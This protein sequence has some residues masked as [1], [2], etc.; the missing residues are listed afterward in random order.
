MYVLVADD[1][2][3]IC[4]TL[5]FFLLASELEAQIIGEVDTAPL[6]LIRVAQVQP[7][8]VLLDWELPGLPKSGGNQ[9]FIAALRTCCPHLYIIGLSTNFV[10]GGVVL[11]AGADAFVSKANPPDYLLRAVREAQLPIL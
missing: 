5:R 1:N 6:L 3:W 8:L 9:P 4:R 11:A 2:Q 7:D 10:V